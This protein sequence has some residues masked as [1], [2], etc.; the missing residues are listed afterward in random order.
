MH[1]V[2]SKENLQKGFNA[3][4]K[5]VAS[6]AILPILSNVLF[7]ATSD[8]KLKLSATDLEIGVETYVETQVLTSGKI[9]LPARVLQ[10][11]ISKLP[12]D[13]D[14]EIQVNEFGT[15]TLLKC[16]RSKFNL[17]SLNADDFPPLPQLDIDNSVQ[18]NREL[19]AQGIKKTIF[20]AST[21][22]TKNVLNGVKL[23]L[24]NEKLEMAATDGYRLAVKTIHS[25]SKAE[26]GF[27]VIVPS[28][29]LNELSRL[30][31]LGKEEMITVSQLANQ[32]VFGIDDKILST[33]LIE[34]QYPD[35]NRII[36]KNLDKILSF[37]R[38]EFLSTVD[39]VAAISSVEKVNLVKMEIKNNEVTLSSSTPESGQSDETIEV[40]YQGDHFEINFNARFLM[41]AV[42]N[43][44][45]E[46]I[47]FHLAGSLSP[48]ILKGNDD[49]TYFCMIMPIRS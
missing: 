24:N 49:E 44:D 29:A 12:V 40:N 41:D 15:E 30:L 7:E 18:L 1:I 34:G 25:E 35:Y 48:G 38:A 14:V 2:C 37:D 31:S 46:Q 45:T 47:N 32:L 26:Q 42:R 3:V 20:A 19:M 17:K 27:S 33:R 8:N 10:D 5:A 13:K 21:D 36:P 43:F 9:S 28:R 23:Y 6:R 11:I 22:T 4:S 16:G 39:R